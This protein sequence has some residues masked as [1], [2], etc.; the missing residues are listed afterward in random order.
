MLR[1]TLALTAV[2]AMTGTA[3]AASWAEGLF[4]ELSYDFGQVPRGPVQSFSFRLTNKTGEPVHISS[5]R[6]GCHCVT[7]SAT[8]TDLAA[9][10]STSIAV[11]VDTRRL[12]GPFQKPIFVQF[13]RPK[14]EEVR[15]S[16][17]ANIR[18][19][20]HVS[21]ESLAFGRVKRG[22]SSEASVTVLIS[23]L[24]DCKLQEAKC[25]SS[26]L[27]ARIER[28]PADSGEYRVTAQLRP[29]LPTGRWYSTVWVTTNNS[30]LPRFP[31]PITVEVHAPE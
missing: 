12:S 24:A 21:P 5:V 28:L 6:V 18:D 9:G 13:D 8:K 26:Y 17:K 19:D 1:L 4:G 31:I 7:A 27:R 22:S 10:E 25:D 20:L 3:P 2:L 15:L 29:G 30:A 11:Q 16:V 23:G 14:S